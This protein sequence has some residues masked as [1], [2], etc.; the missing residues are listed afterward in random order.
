M[1]IHE[2]DFRRRRPKNGEFFVIYV[3]GVEKELNYLP[4]LEELCY[5]LPK[6][7]DIELRLVSPAVRHLI[8]K[9]LHGFPK[10]YLASCGGYVIDKTAPNG[11]RVRVSLKERHA[12]FH[13]VKLSS[14]PDAV[15]GLNA[16]I[17]DCVEWPHTVMRLLALEIPFSFSEHTQHVL[18][19]VKDKLIPI[20]IKN[21]N[22][23]SRGKRR[24][25]TAPRRIEIR[26]NP[27]HGIVGRNQATLLIP[28]ISNGYLLTWKSTLPELLTK[29]R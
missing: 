10:S 19:T 21:Y 25:V 8:Y 2:F 22:A 23:D 3:L 16:G 17:A 9:A 11:G 4:L 27:F 24:N 6:G 18:R 26:L 20:W 7:T 15:V 29:S 1:L 14:V 5:L 28:N 13:E 12:L